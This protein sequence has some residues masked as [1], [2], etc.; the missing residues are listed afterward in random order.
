MER[1]NAAWDKQRSNC[2]GYKKQFQEKLA[3]IRTWAKLDVDDMFYLLDTA[4]TSAKSGVIEVRDLMK[5]RHWSATATLH[6]GG[7]GNARGIDYELHFN[8]LFPGAPPSTQRRHFH[9]RCK[10]LPNDKVVVF[11]IT[12]RKVDG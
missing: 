3:H 12:D 5:R 2:L 1:S 8:I 11:E 7:F 4:S 10:E 9:V 6:R